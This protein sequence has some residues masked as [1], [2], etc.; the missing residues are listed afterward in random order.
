MPVVVIKVEYL[1]GVEDPEALTILKNLNILGYGSVR[2]V[3]TSKSYELDIEG[4]AAE[5]RKTAEDIA[6]RILTNPVI[7]K[8]SIRILK[9]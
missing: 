7:Q 4:S 8:Y 5:V 2:T 1:P 3:Q 9:K 6:G